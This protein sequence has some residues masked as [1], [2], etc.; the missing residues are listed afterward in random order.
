M[1]KTYPHAYN[2]VAVTAPVTIGY[3]RDSKHGTAYFVGQALKA[4]IDRAGL[5]K[6]DV[7]G[8]A[9]SSLTLKP[10]TVVAMTTYLGI[11]PRWIED[12]PMGGASG[13]V[14]LKRAA[15]AIQMGDAEIIACIGADA[16]APGAFR[17]LVAD[18][19]RF[20]RDTVY[21]Y[22]AAG[23]NMVFAMI[24]R[25]YM[26]KFG[27]TRED[28]GRLCV[29]QRENAL[30]NP[31][32]ILKKPLTLEDYMAARPI[33]EPLH[34]FDCV[35]PCAGAEA[36]LVMSEARAKA[37]GLSHATIKGAVERYNAYADDPIPTR[38]GWT[39][40]ADTLYGMA[41]V[42]PKDMDFLQTYDDYPVISLL[43]MEGLGFCKEG[44]AP[45]FIR[46][47]DLTVGG[48]PS[49][50]RLPHNTSGGQLSAGQAGAAGG[51]LGLTEAIRQLTGE[52]EGRQIKNARLGMVSGYGMVI[53]DR[54]LCTS[55]AILERGGK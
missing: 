42:G 3:E 10:D 49:H 8:L 55:A 48:G 11:S 23:P 16:T 43:Q 21:P 7:D 24:T 4:L 13:V 37:L 34:L 38:S 45:A 41:G 28:F 20:S 35:M 51:F 50:N 36:F 6:S 12:I 19:S 39:M 9:L 29:A 52:A 53:Y 33:A 25:N 18:F 14:A 1:T 15:R 44:E 30:K 5:K 46:N 2:A 32:A 17:D 54:C 26:E 47:T 22:G 27:A 31:H 40:E